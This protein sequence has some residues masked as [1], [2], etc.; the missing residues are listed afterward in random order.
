MANPDKK[1]K[2]TK[3]IDMVEYRRKKKQRKLNERIL[4]I[5]RPDNL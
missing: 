5:K 1:K 3:V 2:E 4:D